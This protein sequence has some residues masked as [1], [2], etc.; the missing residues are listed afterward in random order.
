M[1]EYNFNYTFS[2]IHNTI[3]TIFVYN[4]SVLYVL[5]AP[6]FSTKALRRVA[7]LLFN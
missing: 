3:E 2:N 6:K 5:N 4:I 7:R 1:K